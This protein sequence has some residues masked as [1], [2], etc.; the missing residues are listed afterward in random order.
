[1]QLGKLDLRTRES[2]MRGGEHGAS[3]VPGAEATSKLIRM[4]SG[5]DTPRMPLG[6]ALTANEIEV[7][8]QWIA[9]GARY[10]ERTLVAQQKLGVTPEPTLREAD[11]KWWAF[12]P[13]RTVGGSIDKLLNEPMAKAGVKPAPRA[14]RATLVRRAYLDLLGLP[15]TPA[16]VAAFVNSN[17]PQAWPKLIDSL[18]A[19]PHYGERWGRHWLDVARYADSNGYEHD[20]DRPNAWRYRDYVIRAFNEDKPYDVFLT[21]Q[22]AGDEIEKPT[23]DSLTATGFLRS[24]AKVGYREKDNPEFRFEYLDDMIATVGRGV[25]GLTVQCARCHDHKFDPISQKDYYRMQASLF[26]YV[27][28]DHPLAPPAEATAWRE[29]NARVDAAIAALRDRLREIEAPYAARILPGKYKRFPANVQEA[30]A[31]PEEKRTP[32]QVLLANQ[33]IRTTRA[34]PAEIDRICSAE[35]LTARRQIQREMASLE[36]QRPSAP[37]LAM[38]VT[39]GDYR[40]TPDGA[41]DEPA[42]GKGIKTEA[43]A[44]SFLH[45]GPGRYIAPPSFL[46]V[47]GDMHAKAEP[48]KPG[49]PRV[50]D[51]GGVPPELETASGKT[52]GRRLALAKSLLEQAGYGPSKPLKFEYLYRST[53][54]NP[55][56]A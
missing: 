26:G 44:G 14:G 51:W 53:G 22:L 15:P 11:R 33:V 50:V 45:E 21:E 41:G 34:T 55:R 31:T 17:D 13:V 37:A 27:E 29:G 25:M 32:G 30:I 2:A 20:F 18:L 3:I 52:A 36:K 42:P 24:Y 35:D 12:Q 10:P 4:V 1:M 43:I 54:D 7:L 16:E 40:F 56:I 48:M 19:S 49:F 47:R 28:V 46:L 38:G 5:L 6:G 8:R 23:Y 9:A 39:D